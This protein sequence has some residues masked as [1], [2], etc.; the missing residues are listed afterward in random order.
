MPDRGGGFPRGLSTLTVLVV[1]LAVG[2]HF[3]AGVT[4]DDV[5]ERGD[6]GPLEDVEIPDVNPPG[7]G[8]SPDLEPPDADNSPDVDP[9]DGIDT[10]PPRGEQESETA[11]LNR[12]EIEYAVHEQVN[13]QRADHELEALEFDDELREVARY[14]SRDMAEE[15]YFAHTSPDGDT[16]GDR[17][18]R[19]G[20]DCRVPTGDGRYATGGENLYMIEFPTS[21]YDEAE[22]AEEAVDGWMNSEGHRE[23]M[24]ADHWEHQGI[25]VVVTEVDDGDAVAVYVTQNFC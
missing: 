24:L 2:L 3:G 1:L 12:T 25:G 15:G 8:D 4:V 10:E 5:R 16:L 6:T 17:Y 23:N 21:T 13:D 14:H 11:E 19:F 18:N 9:P 7:A 20:Y 22:I